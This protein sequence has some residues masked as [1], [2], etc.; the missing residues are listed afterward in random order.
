MANEINRILKLFT[1]L[2]HGD[3]WIGTNFKEVLH[4]VG[5]GDAVKDISGNT[6]NTWM[7]VAHITYWRSTVVNRLTGSS[8]PP[9]FTDFL[10]P[11]NCDEV[12]WRQ[13]LHDFEAAYHL[14]RNAI[15]HFDKANLYKPSPRKDQ[16]F[17][18]LMMGCLQH[19]AYHLGQ[20]MIL[21]NVNSV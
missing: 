6:N 20:L 11:D 3:C 18:D 2:Q 19:D 1:D 7:L 10:L 8:N 9:P 4:G 5:A 16:T 15:H 17:Y 12:N 13:T 21:K 14:L